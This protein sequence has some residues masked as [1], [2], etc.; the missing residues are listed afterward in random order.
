MV[1][2]NN[3]YGYTDMIKVKRGWFDSPIINHDPEV[4]PHTINGL[5]NAAIEQFKFSTWSGDTE[6]NFSYTEELSLLKG[7]SDDIGGLDNKFVVNRSEFFH[8]KHRIVEGSWFIIDNEKFYV[9]KQGMNTFEDRIYIKRAFN[10]FNDTEKS[11]HAA[12]TIVYVDNS[13]TDLS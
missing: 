4:E 6:P 2:E 8:P 1:V 5:P 13:F 7:I 10:D 12:G 11:Y 3:P 9:Y